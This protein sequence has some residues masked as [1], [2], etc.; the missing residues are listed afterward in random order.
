MTYNVKVEPVPYS[1]EYR[2][3]LVITDSAGEREYWDGG[4]PEDN[5][6]G[7]DW[8]WIANELRSAYEQG[9]RASLGTKTDNYNDGTI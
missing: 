1:H 7:R 4:E 8:S 3:R 5:S 9:K 2:S 6:F